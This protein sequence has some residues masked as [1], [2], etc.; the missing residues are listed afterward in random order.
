MSLLTDFKE[1]RSKI[2]RANS[3]AELIFDTERFIGYNPNQYRLN[4]YNDRKDSGAYEVT[5]DDILDRTPDNV[6][7]YNDGNKAAFNIGDYYIGCVE[8]WVHCTENRDLTVTATNDDYGA[9]Y[10][11]YELQFD[12]YKTGSSE[13]VLHFK[14]GWNHFQ[15]VFYE[16]S[17]GDSAYINVSLSTQDFVDYMYA[18]VERS[19]V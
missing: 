8:C 4:R 15:H 6:Y 18:Y 12:N 10:L 1:V 19:E 9:L 16:H 11:N 13:G 14:K 2:L 7:Y 17:G 3:L 5:L